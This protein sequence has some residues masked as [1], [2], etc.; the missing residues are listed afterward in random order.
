MAKG[1]FSNHYP[2]K[3]AEYLQRSRI[4]VP[5]VTGGDAGL[6]DNDFINHDDLFYSCL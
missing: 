3:T 6:G 4:W 5:I 1:C 2:C